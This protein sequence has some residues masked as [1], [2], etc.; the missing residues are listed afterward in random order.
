MKTKLV[1]GFI[2]IVVI[3]G[4][5]LIFNLIP[6]G[7]PQPATKKQSQT[8]QPTPGNFYKKEKATFSYTANGFVPKNATVKLGQ[9]VTWT[10]DTK[11]NMSLNSDNHPT[12]VKFPILN[13]GTIPPDATGQVTFDKV[14][15]YT[16][17]D[18]YKPENRGTVIVE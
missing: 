1:I 10:N 3:I 15:T 18:H 5:L 17:H 8:T 2:V 4:I 11:E 6:F 16:F 9:V 12:H 13:V 14:G 7:K